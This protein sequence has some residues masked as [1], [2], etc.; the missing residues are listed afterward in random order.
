MTSEDQI[1][2]HFPPQTQTAQT[3]LDKFE[4]TVSNTFET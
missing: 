1:T 4:G 2:F 3:H